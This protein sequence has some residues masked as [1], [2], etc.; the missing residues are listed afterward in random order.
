MRASTTRGA[1][2]G[3]VVRKLTVPGG[4]PASSRASAIRAWVLGQI[5]EA[6]KTTALPQARGVARAR[7]PRITGAFQGARLKTTPTGWRTAKARVPGRSEG[8]TSPVIW[9]VRAAASLNIPAARWTLKWAQPGVAPVSR[10][11]AST[12][13]SLRASRAKAAFQ[14][15][16][17]R[18]L[19][20]VSDQ[21][22]N[23]LWAA[24][25]AWRASSR[26]AAAAR[27]ATPPR[28]LI[29]SN[30]LPERLGRHSPPTR[31]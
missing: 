22:S 29:L 15:T 1:S 26:S 5:S 8:M 11:M 2:S 27:V 19:G 9:V 20:G 10:V 4:R 6:L 25:T 16:S 14:R 21:A 23:P 24:S 31:S 18:T 28:G 7:T 3:A 30:T 13:A 17:R 12:K